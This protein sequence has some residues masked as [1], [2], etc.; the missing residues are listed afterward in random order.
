MREGDRQ[1]RDL[2]IEAMFRKGLA[3]S[4]IAERVGLGANRVRDVLRA[5]GHVLS[6]EVKHEED[7][8]KSIWTRSADARRFAIWQRAKRAAREALQAPHS[9]TPAINS[10]HTD[11]NKACR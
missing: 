8:Y 3:P 2:K 5:R 10:I 4:N 1:A 11:E 7:P 9:D 6:A